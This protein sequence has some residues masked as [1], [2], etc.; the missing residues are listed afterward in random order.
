MSCLSRR[1]PREA[2]TQRRQQV[3]RYKPVD[4]QTTRQYEYKHKRLML[5]DYELNYDN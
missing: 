2:R 5:V 3:A 4:I 1:I